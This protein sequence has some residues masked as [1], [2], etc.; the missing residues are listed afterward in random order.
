VYRGIEATVAFILNLRI[1][2]KVGGQFHVPVALPIR[3][4]S[5]VPN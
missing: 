1:D 3:N 2:M 5:T 4:D